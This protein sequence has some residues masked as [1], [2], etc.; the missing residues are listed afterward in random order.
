MKL[1]AKLWNQLNLNW[2][3]SIDGQYGDKWIGKDGVGLPALP[4]SLL[5]VPDESILA[6]VPD[7]DSVLDPD[8]S[9]AALLASLKG[10]A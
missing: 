10:D 5:D 9:E 2:D 4:E 1:W 7:A 8:C 3:G 6:D